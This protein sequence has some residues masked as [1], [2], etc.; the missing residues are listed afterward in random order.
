MI[1]YCSIL[2]ITDNFN[3]S[4][5]VWQEQLGLNTIPV[6][7]QTAD[8]SVMTLMCISHTEA[9]RISYLHLIG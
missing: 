5:H 8:C 1:N 2:Y 6:H 7:R 4:L 3:V 9:I